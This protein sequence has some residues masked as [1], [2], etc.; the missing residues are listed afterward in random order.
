MKKQEKLPKITTVPDKKLKPITGKFIKWYRNPDGKYYIELKHGDGIITHCVNDRIDRLTD[1]ISKL[2]KKKNSPVTDHGLQSLRNS[3]HTWQ[4]IYD[5]MYRAEPL[6]KFFTGG[7]QKN[8]PLYVQI[9]KYISERKKNGV[10]T[11]D[12]LN[13]AADYFGKDFLQ[14]KRSYYYKPEKK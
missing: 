1:S 14:V 9:Q 7:K 10:K 2:E 5:A 11:V 13:D 3:L 8:Q 4:S 6:E 12:L